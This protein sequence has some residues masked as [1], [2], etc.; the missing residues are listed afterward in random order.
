M[1]VTKDMLDLRKA[2]RQSEGGR[3]RARE[4][5]HY[6]DALA[7]LI[8]AKHHGRIIS[9]KAR[10]KA[11]N[12]VNLIDGLKKSIAKKPR[13]GGS[14]GRPQVAGQK[15]MLLPIEGKKPTVRNPSAR[16]RAARRD[17]YSSFGGVSF[18]SL[19]MSNVEPYCSRPVRCRP[20]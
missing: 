1:K 6:E 12:V 3:L 17:N 13:K 16:Q 19:V 10:P 7:E 8:N 14:R 5:D 2:H 18:R 20:A 4:E 15:E 11:D 9:A